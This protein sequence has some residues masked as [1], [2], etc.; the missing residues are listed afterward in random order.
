MADWQAG[1]LE[2]PTGAKL[3]TYAMPPQGTETG[4]P[5]AVV[6]INHGMAE[7]GDRYERFARFLAGLG[8]ASFA[9]DHRGHGATTAPDAPLG[10][11]AASDGW[12]RVIADVAAVNA[13]LREKFDGAPILCFGHSMGG[14]IAFD[15][16]LSHPETVAAGAVWNTSLDTP[17]LLG[18][19]AGILRVE[20]FL[21]GSDTPS[22]IATTLTFNAWN[23]RFAPNRTEFD[24][25]SRDE[26][27]VD[28]YVADPLCG[29]PVSIGTWLSVIGGIRRGAD[30]S[31][32]G[33]LPKDLPFNLAA[34]GD[35]PVSERGKAIEHLA[36]RLR[37]AGL[38]DVSETVRE[39]TRHEGLNEINRDEIMASFGAWLDARFG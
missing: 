1:E 18:V 32:L 21:K 6:Q 28:K 34:G 23:K 39:A 15:Y 16:C 11:F 26:A 10:V 36:E 30:D 9:H 29:F 7:H 20:K 14:I 2:S 4:K 22:N 38:T 8:Y 5:K 3:R 17:A 25:L 35:D 31:R 19:L 13:H 12:S 24:W 27:E 33:V 37:M